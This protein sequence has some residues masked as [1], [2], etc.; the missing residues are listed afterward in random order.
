MGN[1]SQFFTQTSLWVYILFFYLLFIGIKSLKTR[2]VSLT[3]LFFLPIIFFFMSLYNLLT[4][5]ELTLGLVIIYIVS[6]TLGS[7]FGW[8]FAQNKVLAFDKKHHLIKLQGSATTLILILLIFSIKY[9]FGYALAVDPTKVHNVT[10]SSL[11]ILS[12]GM[13]TGIFI[14]RS[15]LYLHKRSKAPHTD[16]K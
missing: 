15:F 2:V 9:Y 16:L 6:L 1:L 14:G 13:V 11:M 3:R 5:F 7:W 12:S 8:L 10:F 4:S